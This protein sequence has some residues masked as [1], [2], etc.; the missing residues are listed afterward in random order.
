M[1]SSNRLHVQVFGSVLSCVTGYHVV[2][3]SPFRASE[4]YFRTNVTLS[5]KPIYSPLNN[6]TYDD[7]YQIYNKKKVSTNFTKTTSHLKTESAKWETRS[8]FSSLLRTHNRCYRT[9]FGR[10]GDLCTPALK[11]SLALL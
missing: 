4:K 10:P 9:K 2:F 1:Y 7:R 8:K 3:L 5:L 11:I 6:T